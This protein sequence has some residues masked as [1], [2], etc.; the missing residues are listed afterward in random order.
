MYC[1]PMWCDPTLTAA[2]ILH[3]NCLRAKRATTHCTYAT[4]W[5]DRQLYHAPSGCTGVWPGLSYSNNSGGSGG[6]EG[7]YT[8]TKSSCPIVTMDEDQKY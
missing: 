7:E 3:N 6:F 1:D 5:D 2:K 8:V 4:L